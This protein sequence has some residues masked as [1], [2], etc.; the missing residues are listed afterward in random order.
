[1][2]GRLV[3]DDPQQAYAHAQA[4]RQLAPRLPLVREAV[5]ETAYAAGD[6]AQALTEFRT[7][8]RMSGND[9]YLPAI[10][11]CERALGRPREALKL[12]RD[13]LP[14]ASD[15]A[16]VVELRLVEAGARADLGERD[17]ALRV[18]RDQIA[19]IGGRGP[20]AARARLRYGYADQLEQAGRVQEAEE[21]FAAV[22]ALDD[23]EAT[24]ADERLAALRGVE[25]DYEAL[26]DLIGDID[27]DGEADEEE[28]LP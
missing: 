27:A 21:W 15:V 6:Y 9:D 11:D 8:R 7:V 20:A 28:P 1:M 10:A 18:L 19:R 2:A 22:V 12:I 23:G 16:H 3:D 24:D 5:G 13:G 26:E 4:A 25:I 17:E 14:Q